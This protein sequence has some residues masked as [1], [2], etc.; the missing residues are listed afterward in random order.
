MRTHQCHLRCKNAAGT[1][2]GREGLIQLRHMPSNGGLALYQIHFIP[3][4]SDLQGG[5][6]AR[7]TPTHHQGTGID[8]NLPGLQWMLIENPPYRSA[9]Q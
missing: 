4:I 2:Q 9:Q 6:N 3:G 7:D 8:R 1:I 5:L